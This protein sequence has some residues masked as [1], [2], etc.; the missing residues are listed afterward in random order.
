MAFDL[1]DQELEATRGMECNKKKYKWK[2]SQDKKIE[3][4]KKVMSLLENVDYMD[5]R[6]NKDNQREIN[7]AYLK[8][9]KLVKEL[10]AEV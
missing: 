7:K 9:E 2:K 10:E 5:F 8:L 1:D 3:E 6:R 4:I